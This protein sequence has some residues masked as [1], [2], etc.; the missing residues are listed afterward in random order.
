MSIVNIVDDINPSQ[1]RLQ[2]LF[3]RNSTEKLTLIFTSRENLDENPILR[4]EL[5]QRYSVPEYIWT[6][7]CKRLQGYFGSEDIFSSDDTTIE[8]HVTWFHFEI[9]YPFPPPKKKEGAEDV[10]PDPPPQD[11]KNPAGYAWYKIAIITIWTAPDQHTIIFIDA[12]NS[13]AHS[14]RNELKLNCENVKNEVALGNPY[15]AHQFLVGPI[16]ACYDQ[17]VWNLRDLVKAL[18]Q[19][20]RDGK[21]AVTNAIDS[22]DSDMEASRNTFNSLHEILRHALHKT[23]IL[24][25]AIQTLDSICSRKRIFDSERYSNEAAVNIEAPESVAV[26]K[27]C[28]EKMGVYLDFQ[29]SIVRSLEARARANEARIRSEI[30]LAFSIVAQLDSQ[31]QAKIGEAAR[32]DSNTM[33]KIAAVTMLFLPPSFVSAVFS[34]SFF[35]FSPEP[36]DKVSK[37]FWIF[38]AISI[39][40]TIIVFG[41]LYPGGRGLSF[42]RRVA[43]AAHHKPSVSARTI[44]P[45]ESLGMKSA[46]DI[47]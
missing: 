42:R 35:S 8:S 26:A 11:G 34:T 30:T 24:G 44:L 19:G 16:L 2:D 18:E 20:R 39:P 1:G 5:F 10:P 31:V 36:D 40:L 6:K 3:Q 37:D 32:N 33:V 43:S 13:P 46:R 23:E 12:R 14:I 27:R 38:W 9:K 7:V 17:A 25:V 21:H 29:L 22:N 41:S 15:W 47:V 28:A 4:D 45:M